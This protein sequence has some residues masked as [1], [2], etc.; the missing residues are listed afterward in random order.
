MQTMMN[1]LYTGTT[2]STKP[3]TNSCSKSYNLVQTTILK[4]N[5]YT[6]VL[7]ALSGDSTHHK[8][9]IF[10]IIEYEESCGDDSYDL[11]QLLSNLPCRR[12]K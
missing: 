7:D 12:A 8:Y 3:I 1:N 6:I 5:K 11:F 10:N 2:I 4:K 9:P